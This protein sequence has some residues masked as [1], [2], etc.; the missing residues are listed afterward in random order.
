MYVGGPAGRCRKLPTDRVRMKVV[1][2]TGEVHV[3]YIPAQLL[4]RVPFDCRSVPDEGAAVQTE[5]GGAST[6]GEYNVV[7]VADIL[8]VQRSAG[9]DRNHLRIEHVILDAHVL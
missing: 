3:E 8:P 4:P 6:S 9:R 5:V 1:P 2:H 7:V